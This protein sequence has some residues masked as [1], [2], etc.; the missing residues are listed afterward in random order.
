ML[1]FPIYMA[2]RTDHYPWTL[3]TDELEVLPLFTSREQAEAL[4]HDADTADLVVIEIH[5]A[6]EFFPQLQAAENNCSEVWWNPHR[7]DDGW[8]G[9]NPCAVEELMFEMEDARDARDRSERGVD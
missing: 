7:T 8:R 1:T 4:A 6:R 9:T 2:I 5:S 3:R